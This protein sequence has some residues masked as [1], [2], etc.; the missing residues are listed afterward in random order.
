MH[1][2]MDPNGPGFY[3]TPFGYH[4]W[5]GLPHYKDIEMLQAMGMSCEP[6]FAADYHGIA[7]TPLLRRDVADASSTYSKEDFMTDRFRFYGKAHKTQRAIENIDNY[8]LGFMNAAQKRIVRLDDK[9]LRWVDEE[10]TV[11]DTAGMYEER[12]RGRPTA[13]LNS[14]AAPKPC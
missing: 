13:L 4:I 11:L 9:P 10:Q 3:T 7:I 8:N 14:Q 12:L 5:P 6:G 1:D 2:E